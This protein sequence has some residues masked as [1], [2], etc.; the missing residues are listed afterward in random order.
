MPPAAH[1]SASRK[2]PTIAQKKEAVSSIM[3][4]GK[5][6]NIARQYHLSRAAVSKW[7][8]KF[9]DDASQSLCDESRNRNRKLK[10]TICLRNAWMRSW[11][12]ASM[13]LE[14]PASDPASPLWNVSDIV[15]L[16]ALYLMLRST[17]RGWESET[18]ADWQRAH[19]IRRFSGFRGLVSIFQTKKWIYNTLSREGRGWERRFGRWRSSNG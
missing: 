14:F 19:W 2:L 5:A 9:R 6:S 8:K 15:F 10:N 11:L 7:V 4:G 16:I 17:S 13:P 18:G 12:R 1:P 3:A